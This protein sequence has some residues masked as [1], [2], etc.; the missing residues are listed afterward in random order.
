MR[1]YR[2]ISGE[3]PRI[4][5]HGLAQWKI[6]VI[7][8]LFFFLEDLNESYVEHLNNHAQKDL[9]LEATVYNLEVRDFPS[10]VEQINK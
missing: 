6:Y 8:D 1:D 4:L 2:C 5:S 3:L 7:C 9:N 10:L